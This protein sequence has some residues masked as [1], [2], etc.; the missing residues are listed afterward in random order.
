MNFNQYFTNEQ[1]QS[2]LESWTESYPNL[3]SLI[4]IGKS[5]ENRPIWLISLTNRNTGD[6]LAKPAL[7]IDANIHATELAGSTTALYITEHLLTAYGNNETITKLL[8]SSVIYLVP[9]VNPDGAA[10]A[11]S[12]NPRFI[13]SGVRLYPWEE[14]DEGLHTQDIN[15][16]QQILQMRIVDPNGDWKISSLDSRLMEKRQP[17]EHGGTY[18]RLFTEGLLSD[19]DGYLVKMARPPQGLDFNRNFPFEWRPEADQYGA[20]PYPASE[21]EVRALVDFISSHP[22]INIAISYHTFSRVILRPYSTKSDDD[23]PTDDLWV[24]KKMGELGTQI[25]G[26]RNASTF[27]EFKYH[28][29]EVTTG[30]F[31]DWMYDHFGA[32]TFTIELWD[33]PTE[34][35]IK[36]RKFIDWWREHPHEEDLQILKWIYQHAP[37]G[38]YADWQ[39]FEHPQLGQV[40]LGGWNS[41][42]TWRN[43]PLDFMEAEAARHLPFILSLGN[44]LPKLHIHTLKTTSL[45][46]GN[47]SLNL[48]VE[49]SGFLPSYTSQQAKKRT[50][51]RPL[52]V[53]LELPAKCKLL[54]G[55]RRSELGH[56]EGRSNKL[57]VTS[58]GANSPMDNRARLEWTLNAPAGTHITI[59]ITSERAGKLT[60]EHTLE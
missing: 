56:L 3:A 40:E 21:P 10:C 50:V 26:Y 29:K 42:Y 52:L 37:E 31:D 5:H 39:T 59:H 14:L 9:R 35:G 38:A 55:K 32:F 15:Q 17:D 28:P 49:N 22:N 47:Y 13:R 20:G 58:L 48:V 6:D 53:E 19:Y 18:Y 2:I 46:N 23:M 60:L 51:V 57:D 16:D 27:H 1:I 41:L 7:W 34:A 36:D 44:L 54:T 8:D 43:P 12:D 45:S 4:Q 24:Y 25:T 30:A 33:L 11:L